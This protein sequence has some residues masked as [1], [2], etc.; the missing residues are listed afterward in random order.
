MADYIQIYTTTEKREEARDIARNVVEKRLAACAQVLGPIASTYWWK[1]MIEEAEEW[2]CIM[3]SRRD[4]YEKLE[5]TIRSIHP[6]EEPEI[7]AVPIEA[8]SRGYLNWLDRE[9]GS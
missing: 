7:L 2:M 9:L 1:G 4:L 8:G 5:A 3:K 6:Y